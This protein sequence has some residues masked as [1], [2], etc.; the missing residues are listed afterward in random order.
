VFLLAMCQ[1]RKI[2]QQHE[3][4]QISPG[5]SDTRMTANQMVTQARLENV[6]MIV[7]IIGGVIGIILSILA[8][9]KFVTWLQERRRAARKV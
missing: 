6:N 4:L 2:L 8:A 9:I 5:H 7:A 3:E 1:H